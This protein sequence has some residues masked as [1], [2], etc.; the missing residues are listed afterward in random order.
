M[1]AQAI[2]LASVVCLTVFGFVAVCCQLG[3]LLPDKSSVHGRR[4]KKWPFFYLSI[5]AL[6]I[7]LVVESATLRTRAHFESFE[8]LQ[9]GCD[10]RTAVN[11]D[12]GGQGVRYSFYVPG[13][14]T[15]V[16]LVIGVWCNKEIGT[17]EIGSAQIMSK[18]SASASHSYILEDRCFS[19]I[20]K[21]HRSLVHHFQLTQGRHQRV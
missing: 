6:W 5:P 13:F 20:A 2:D 21:C 4:F 10:F 12:I 15:I 16:S 7:C 18:Y 1:A 17:K 11:P 19:N 14:L 9:N 8:F 3:E